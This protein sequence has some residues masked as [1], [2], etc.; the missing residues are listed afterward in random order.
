MRQ[1]VQRDL[2][3]GVNRLIDSGPPMEGLVFHRLHLLAARRW[4]ER[5]LPVG[6]ALAV[7]EMLMGRRMELIRSALETLRER[8]DGRIVVLKGPDVAAH[9]PDPA[10]RPTGDVDV[11]VDS[12][13]VAYRS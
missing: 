5:G 9:Y 3:A 7:D 1:A 8:H 13:E 6:G 4:A 2:S 10:L 11:L 12:P